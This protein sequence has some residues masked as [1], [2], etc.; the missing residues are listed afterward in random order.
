MQQ[1]DNRSIVLHR[2]RTKVF[3]FSVDRDDHLSLTSYP[4]QL[5]SYSQ[6]NWCWSL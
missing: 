3:M 4:A 2:R 5:K 6:W 1:Q